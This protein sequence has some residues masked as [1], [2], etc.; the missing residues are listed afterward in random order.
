MNR[1]WIELVRGPA[2]LTV[3][4]DIV[5]GAAA[6]GGAP[7]RRTALAAGS[8][9][10][11]YWSGMA[12][13]DWADRDT[14]ARE[15]PARPLP[16]GRIRPAAALAAAAGLTAAGLTLAAV[17]SRPA[18]AA[19]GALAA[20]AWAY[21]LG[22]KHTTAGP[23]AMGAARSLNVVLGACAG[24]APH[25]ALPAAGVV[26]AHTAAVTALSRHEAFGGPRSAP[27]VTL[28]AALGTAAAVAAPG[29]TPAPR[30][31]RAGSVAGSVAYL[32]TAAPPLLRA[33]REPTGARVRQGV[34]GGL[35]ALMPLQAALAAR[36]GRPQAV[37]VLLGALA[38]ARRLSRKVTPT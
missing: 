33:A 6:A 1:A 34:V 36:A 27:L 30:A 9:L 20:T 2:A 15:R 35:T 21:D 7:L 23:A 5:A 14:D 18:L 32:L 28:A 11:L 26:G 38:A 16:S 29:R 12:L 37:P 8:S 22:V 31:E 13:N 3:P 25:R 19:A 17:H 4:G 10:C 24:R